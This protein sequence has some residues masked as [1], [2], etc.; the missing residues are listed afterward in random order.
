VTAEDTPPLKLLVNLPPGF[1]TAPQLTPAWERLSAI[2]GE[3]RQTSCNTHD[4]ITTHWRWADAVLM[5]SWPR[6]TTEHLAEC[7]N[8]RFAAML[9]VTQSAAQALLDAGV[10]VS[11]AK[12]A[13]SPAVA[14]MALTLVLSTLRRTPSHQ[15]AMWAGTETWVQ[16]FPDDIDPHERQLTGRRV[17]LVGFGGIGQRLA[18][19]LAPFE[20]HV[21]VHDPYLPPVVAERFGV[22]N[23]PVDALVRHAEV[24][25]VCAAANPGTRHLLTAEHVAALAPGAVL[26]NVSRATLIDGDA[27]LARLRKGD[28]YA[29]LDVFEQEPLPADS[30]LRTLPNVYLTPHRAGGI[31]ESVSRL[32][33]YLTDDL[34]AY[35]A[36]RPLQHALTPALLPSLDA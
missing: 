16:R 33:A 10:P 8:L 18:Q 27:L 35:L 12:R 11:V 34:E 36:G 29:A 28:L 30:A 3:V 4:E 25:V 26:V 31:Y 6:F 20:C 14:E 15:S 9:D 2:A 19:L 23:V 13:F 5:W 22:E 24:L 21:K 7:P 1:F 17:G 32:L